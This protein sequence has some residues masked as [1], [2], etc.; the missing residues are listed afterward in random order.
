MPARVAGAPGAV[1]LHDV[2]GI[3]L[4]EKEVAGIGLVLSD[5]YPSAGQKVFR[6][7]PGEAAVV[8]ETL[9]REIDLPVDFIGM[10]LL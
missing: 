2:G 3:F 5:F 1:P 4:P 7:V 9:D 6:G 10:S 8:G